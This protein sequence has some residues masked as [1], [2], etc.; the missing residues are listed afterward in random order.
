[1]KQKNP[2]AATSFISEHSAEYILVPDL[3]TV[4]YKKYSSV[5][6][7]YFWATREGG[8][9]AAASMK[10]SQ[11]RLVTAFARRPKTSNPGDSDLILKINTTLLQAAAAGA[12][13]GSP[14]FAGVPLTTD[15]MRL[16]IG[17]PCAWFALLGKG[18]YAGDVYIRLSLTEER[19]NPSNKAGL[20][21]GPLTENE[22]VDIVS[23][24]ATPMKWADA[25]ETMKILRR[26]EK[27]Y[28]WYMGGYRPFFLI[29]PG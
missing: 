8:R 27:E 19:H 26:S 12:R 2:Y 20:I 17:I 5:V 21:K 1:M 3:A 23:R 18:Q 25:V 24:K 28:G 29:I 16:Q 4:L 9:L 22:I 14:V 11:V 10:A 6:P 7:I 13:L 15:L